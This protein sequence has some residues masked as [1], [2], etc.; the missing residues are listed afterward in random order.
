MLPIATDTLLQQRYRILKTIGE[1]SAGHS[2]LAS[3]SARTVAAGRTQADELCEIQEFIPTTQ[4]PGAVAQ[5]KEFFKQ[6][7]ILLYQLQH[8]QIPRFWATFEEQNRLFLVLDY[9]DG[10]N[11]R[12]LLDERRTTGE[13]FSEREVWQLLMQVLPALSYLHSQGAIHRNISPESITIRSRDLLPVLS[14]FGVVSEFAERLQAQTPNLQLGKPGYAP[15]EQINSGQFYP[16]SDLY[17]L[18]VTAI[19]LLTAKEPLALFDG[20]R[21]NWDWRQWTQIGDEFASVLQRMLNPAPSARYQ[22]ASE[23][24]R[25]LQSVKTIGQATVATPMVGPDSRI[26]TQVVGVERGEPQ[27]SGQAAITHQRSKSIWEQPKVFIPLGIAIAALAGLGSWFVVSSFIHNQQAETVSAPAKPVEFKNPTIPTDSSASSQANEQT[28]QPA[29]D[30]VIIKDGTVDPV[31]PV[32]YKFAGIGGQNLD[33]QL[34]SPTTPSA[35][36]TQ[37][38]LAPDGTA[39]PGAVSTDPTVSPTPE[40]TAS[41]P[42]SGGTTTATKIAPTQVLLTVLSPT[43]TPIDPQAD[44]VVGWRGQLTETGDY[45]IEIRPIAGLTGKSYPYKLSVAQLATLPSPIV[46]PSQTPIP[47][48]T[49]TPSPSVGISAPIDGNGITPTPDSATPTPSDVV[50]TV[51]PTPV[52]TTTPQASPS[53]EVNRAPTQPTRARRARRRRRVESSDE[54]TATP[55]RRARVTTSDEETPAPRRR[56]ARVTTSDEETATPRRRAR[57]TTSDEETPTP[58]RRRR[59][60]VQSETNTPAQSTTTTPNAAP[61]PKP[62][63]IDVPSPKAAPIDVPAPRTNSVPAGGGDSESN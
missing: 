44:R 12:Q 2:Y 24:Y 11:Y 52:P 26:P 25:D 60:V 5:A 41:A 42:T 30:R 50:P 61:S 20:D 8:P 63:P 38:P 54:E 48:T 40:A 6:Q 9:I 59:R 17:A 22:S 35:E 45:T 19:V 13:V 29:L 33:I 39:S 37:T 57:V 28:I 55:R 23:V 21:M 32:R 62:V 14:D 27:P 56:R 46:S 43:G 51:T 10:K 7:A 58:R 15:T 31:T 18:A 36:A 34:G 53:S 47:E 3:D 16:N 4:L 1:R 49:P